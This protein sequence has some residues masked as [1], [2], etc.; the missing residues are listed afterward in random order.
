[1]GLGAFE[2]SII[3]EEVNR[4]GGN[5]AACHAQMY[6][7]GAL[8]RHGSE[9]QSAAICPRSAAEAET[10]SVLRH[11]SGGGLRYDEY[12]HLCKTGAR[13]YVVNGEKNWTSR[14]EQS[15]LLMLLARTA[16]RE[17][18]NNRAQELACS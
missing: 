6:I 16:P 12:S 17:A 1:M 4:S 14:I 11:R 5:A 2:A 13:R 10:A 7:M 15:D 9:E 18:G 8:L 3:L